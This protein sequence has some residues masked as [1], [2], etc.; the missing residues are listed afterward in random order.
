MEQDLNCCVQMKPDLNCNVQIDK[1]CHKA[2]V[3]TIE[4]SNIRNASTVV[5]IVLANETRYELL[6]NKT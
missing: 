6:W 4:R 2:S 3:Q 1:Y 5:S